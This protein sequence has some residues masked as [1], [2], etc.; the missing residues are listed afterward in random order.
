MRSAQAQMRNAR[1]TSR[2]TKSAYALMQRYVV[3]TK[4]LMI[5]PHP[6]A[7]RAHSLPHRRNVVGDSA[8]DRQTHV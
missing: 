2:L 6:T 3:G 7:P 1:C 8:V 5:I 4:K